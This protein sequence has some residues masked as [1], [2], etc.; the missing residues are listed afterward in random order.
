MKQVIL[1]LFMVF[2][3][4]GVYAQ[5]EKKSDCGESDEDII[6]NDINSGA[7]FDNGKG[8]Y[9]KWLIKKIDTLNLTN[10][11][12]SIREILSDSIVT[13]IVEFQITNMGKVNEVKI[14]CAKGCLISEIGYY[15]YNDIRMIF[16]NSP[17][18]KPA[19]NKQGIDVQS[20][21][22]QP[23][24]FDLSTTE[25]SNTG[26]KKPV[27]KKKPLQK[28]KGKQKINPKKAG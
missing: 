10:R 11:F 25:T 2:S 3:V 16:L 6:W 28:I 20:K 24:T 17:I 27:I 23:L 12:L 18:W 13:L 15:L 4:S 22:I 7:V 5:T 9:M 1:F 19:K 26:E 14:C 21:K 8:E